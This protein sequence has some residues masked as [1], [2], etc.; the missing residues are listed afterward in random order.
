MFEFEGFGVR[1]QKLRKEKGMTQEELAGRVNVTG[2]AVSKWEKGLAYPDIT[3]IPTLVTILGTEID[4]LFGKKAISKVSSFP[5]THAGMPMVHST[6]YVACYSNK[7]VS[8]VDQT[9]V[10]FADGSTAELTNKLAVN[11]GQG[12]IRF[13]AE[14]DAPE[15]WDG[16]DPGVTK[17][18]VKFGYTQNIEMTI[19]CH[20][21]CQIISSQDDKTRVTASGEARFIK[22]L[23][24]MALD[25]VLV[26]DQK[27]VENYNSRGHK[28]TLI[29]EIPCETGNKLDIK[30]NGS[31]K[32]I[33]EIK[34]FRTGRLFINGGGVIKLQSFETCI[35]T[36]NG[37]GDIAGTHADELALTING[38]GVINWA[39]ANKAKA[40][41]NG[42]G[43]IN[44]ETAKTL[45]M[46]VNGSGDFNIGKMIGGGDCIAK[47]AGRSNITIESGSCDKFDA[48][49]HGSGDIDATN[50]TAHEATIVLHQDGI[51]TLGRVLERSSE[52]IKKKG[53]IK[54]LSRGQA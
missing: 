47:I 12:E 43:D 4:H 27:P 3:L 16:P 8:T 2:Q 48:D 15:E 26:L 50:L 6:E 45:N 5:S 35:A 14:A 10:K 29:I 18:E 22:N 11:V 37:S 36:I 46:R 51:V 31:A 53:E 30:I 17:K 34:H 24:I 52:Q 39:M 7:E 33:S 40:S 28:N 9:G 32:I 25:D 38:S 23:E 13:L 21:D 54:I 42:S 49:I 44:I 1:L 20:Y 41:I 19:N